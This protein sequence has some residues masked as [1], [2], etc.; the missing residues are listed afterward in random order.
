MAELDINEGIC[1]VID[2]IFPE[3]PTI[4]SPDFQPPPMRV[5]FT[6]LRLIGLIGGSAGARRRRHG[7]RRPGDHSILGF[8]LA[9]MTAMEA[10][11]FWRRCWKG[12][13]RP[14]LR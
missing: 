10:S 3:E 4:V 13:G 5:S 7:S 1:D 12:I 6:I 11:S 9:W 14:V 2:V 8:A